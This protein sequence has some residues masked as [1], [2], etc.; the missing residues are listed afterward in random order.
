MIKIFFLL[1]FIFNTNNLYALQ[2][3]IVYKIENEIITNTDIKNEFNYLLA[4]NNQLKNLENEK[5]FSLATKSIIKEKIKKTELLKTLK[6]LEVDEKYLQLIVKKMYSN[7]DIETI[8]EFIDYLKIYRV[9]LERVKEKI[10]IDALWNQLIVNKYSSQIKIDI[11]KIK[12]EINNSKKSITKNYLL[13]EIIYEVENKD[14]IYKKYNDIKKSI[15][16]IG[17]D[18]TVLT[19]SISDSSNTK[20]SIGWVNERSLSRIIKKNIS[21]LKRYEISKPIK[22]NGGVLI[23]KIDNIRE[24]K[25]EVNPEKELQKIVNYQQSKQLQQFSKIYFNK[26]KKNLNIN[27]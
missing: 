11:E 1:I 12:E 5:V 14:E 27:E 4:L 25:A 8:D 22:I 9:D 13:S 23:L 10:Q 17:F 7:L 18:N 6:S 15:E 16:E 21:N 20:G 3:N 26:V 19:Y 2:S 24:D